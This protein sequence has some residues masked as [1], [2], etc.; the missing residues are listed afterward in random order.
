MK[1]VMAQLKQGEADSVT[2]RTPIRFVLSA[3]VDRCTGEKP[4]P[5]LHVGAREMELSVNAEEF[6]MVL[7]HLIRNAQDATSPD[8]SIDVTLTAAGDRALISIVDTG[9][10]MSAQFI[11]NRLFRA[12]DSTKGVQGMG[13]GVYQAR[14]FA[15]KHGGDLQVVSAVGEGTT[16]TMLLPLR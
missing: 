5:A 8:D 11:R 3:A 1:R 6:T 9:S 2:K 12:F 14:E 13:I 15:R 10:G 16:M 4:V 7:T